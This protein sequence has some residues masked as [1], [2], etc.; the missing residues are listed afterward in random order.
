MDRPVTEN[1][2]ARQLRP[3]IEHYWAWRQLARCCSRLRAPAGL[4]R[5]LFQ[6]LDFALSL[7]LPAELL[8]ANFTE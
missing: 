3:L 1:D 5:K 4:L 2:A 6:L 8:L 7:T